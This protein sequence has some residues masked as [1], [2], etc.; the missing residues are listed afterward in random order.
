M[1]E[2]G[3]ALIDQCLLSSRWTKLADD[4][5]Q[6]HPSYL[7]LS[8]KSKGTFLQ[9]SCLLLTGAECL[10]VSWDLWGVD[11]PG[12]QPFQSMSRSISP[13]LVL[14]LL[15][16][17]NQ[18]CFDI[19]RANNVIRH[20]EE[21]LDSL[22]S[23]SATTWDRKLSSSVAPACQYSEDVVSGR[24]YSNGCRCIPLSQGA[25]A[26]AGSWTRSSLNCFNWTILFY[27]MAEL[28]SKV[29]L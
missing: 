27:S 21:M 12:W 5:K 20:I 28:N 23:H 2:G 13:C 1:V 16:F 11:H 29:L 17:S 10:W 6:L 19:A 7:L 18:Y 15:A 9:N 14:C 24:L 8:L 22:T 25:S 4:A 3:T 26:L